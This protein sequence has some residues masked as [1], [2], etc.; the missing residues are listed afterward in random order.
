M[1]TQ[2]MKGLVQVMTNSQQHEVQPR[3]SHGEFVKGCPHVF[4][5]EA[6]DWLKVVER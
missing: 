2:L 4:L 5:L 6:N 1:Q 3:Y